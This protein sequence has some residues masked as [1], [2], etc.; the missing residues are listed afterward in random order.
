MA[1]AALRA[2][3]IR[4]TVGIGVEVVVGDPGSIERSAG[5]AKRINDLRPKE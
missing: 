3:H 4:E 5:K 1:Q 2:G